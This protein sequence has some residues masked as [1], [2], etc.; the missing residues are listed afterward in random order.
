M[1]AEEYNVN[2]NEMLENNCVRFDCNVIH[3]NCFVFEMINVNSLKSMYDS[4][5]LEKRLWATINEFRKR[6]FDYGQFI[7]SFWKFRSQ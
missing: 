1:C 3:S 4:G 5:I 6:K 2:T 7:F